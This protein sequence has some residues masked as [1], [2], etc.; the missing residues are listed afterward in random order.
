MSEGLLVM[1][2][3]EVVDRGMSEIGR[4][5]LLLMGISVAGG[6]QSD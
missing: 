6:K 3:Y 1:S 4:T 2:Y 5:L